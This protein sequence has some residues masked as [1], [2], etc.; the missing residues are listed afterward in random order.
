[1]TTAK[2]LTNFNVSTS[3]SNAVGWALSAIEGT[4]SRP[5]GTSPVGP[6]LARPSFEMGNS[7]ITTIFKWKSQIDVLYR[8][9]S[10]FRGSFSDDLALIIAI[11]NEVRDIYLSQV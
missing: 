8:L 1:M 3:P 10:F 5:G 4:L 6:V 7:E 2:H 9:F 11:N